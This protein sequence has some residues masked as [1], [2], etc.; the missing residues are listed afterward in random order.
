MLD[1]EINTSHGK[2]YTGHKNSKDNN[3]LHGFLT[4]F[5]FYIRDNRRNISLLMT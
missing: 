2:G 1:S 4:G 3:S 5:I